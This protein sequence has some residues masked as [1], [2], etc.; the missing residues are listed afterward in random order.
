MSSHD[1][2][3]KRWCAIQC[4]SLTAVPAWYPAFRAHLVA[5][6]A[7]VTANR[8]I[9]GMYSGFARV[10]PF[11]LIYPPVVLL[12]DSLNQLVDDPRWRLAVAA[13]VGASTALIC[14]PV[15]VLIL[16]KLNLTCSPAGESLVETLARDKWRLWRGS[17]MFAL[18]NG[19]FSVSLLCVYPSAYSALLVSH[20]NVASS[21]IAAAVAS[22]ISNSVSHVP[23]MLSVMKQAT[24]KKVTWS[25]FNLAGF[26]ARNVATTV[27]LIVFYQAMPFWRQ[28]FA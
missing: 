7:L 12:T 19:A 9:G 22:V 6:A 11:Q 14:N 1:A 4:A 28:V 16:R 20:G 26:A 23:D 8:S 27:E 17:G 10:L 15:D 21:I 5:K 3:W 24:G 18:R 2:T 25:G 13:T